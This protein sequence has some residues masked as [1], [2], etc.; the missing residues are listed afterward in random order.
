MASDN[1]NNLPTKK[2]SSFRVALKYG[3]IGGLIGIGLHIMM[4]FLHSK[5]FIIILGVSMQVVNI[6]IIVIA[7]RIYRDKHMR[8][9][10]DMKNCVQ[11]GVTVTLIIYAISMLWYIVLSTFIEPDTYKNFSI[12][13]IAISSLGKTISFGVFVSLII[14]SIMKRNRAIN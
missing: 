12:F 9:Y 8:G 14:A 7:I 1:T 5:F 2:T 11:I 10:I 6:S 4:H 3:V 13:D